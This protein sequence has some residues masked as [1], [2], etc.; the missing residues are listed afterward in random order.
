MMVDARPDYGPESTNVRMGVSISAALGHINNYMH[1]Q[2]II[3][4]TK[5]EEHFFL[6]SISA[7][8]SALQRTLICLPP[9]T[10]Q[11]MLWLTRL[12]S[13]S[14]SAYNTVNIN[15]VVHAQPSAAGSLIRLL[16]SLSN[17]DY[18]DS[19]IPRLSIELPHD[20]DDDVTSYLADHFKWPPT[21]DSDSRQFDLHKRVSAGGVSPKHSSVRF[22]ESF[23]PVNRYLDHV[24]VLSPRI[25]LSPLFYHYLKYALLE[26]KYSLEAANTASHHDSLLGIALS[27]P[28]TYLNDSAVFIPP[29]HFQI[30]ADTPGPSFLW[31]TPS[32]EAA[33]Y[34]GDKWVNILDFAS[35]SLV[36]TK[37]HLKE[38]ATTYPA[39]LEHIYTFSRTRGYS[40]LY[41]QPAG[42]AL[43]VVHNDLYIPPEE[44]TLTHSVPEMG[45]E[46]DD[47]TADPATHLS[48]K[49]DEDAPARGNLLEM[50]DEQLLTSVQ[51]LP[52]LS[53]DGRGLNVNDVRM[54][55]ETFSRFFRREVGECKTAVPA[56][57]KLIKLDTSYLFCNDGEDRFALD[58]VPKAGQGT[59]G[60]G[61]PALN[62]PAK[63]ASDLRSPKNAAIVDYMA[64]EGSG[65]GVVGPGGS[66]STEE[67]VEADD[68]ELAAQD[69]K[70]Q[71]KQPAAVVKEP[72]PGHVKE[73]ERAALANIVEH[74]IGDSSSPKIDDSTENWVDAQVKQNLA[75]NYKKYGDGA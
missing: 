14:L 32:S 29:K 26:Y 66:A 73:A 53:A 62:Q 30:R 56:D 55:A 69:Q 70:P 7:K 72:I 61:Q 9:R 75:N 64:T 49:Q 42:A 4:D 44:Y 31:H 59:P 36:S 19:S 17:A 6:D 58:T 25:E 68:S 57:K 67:S 15:I 12:D 37:E 20:I 5:H 33:L 41:P 1:P 63:P 28:H 71:S 22:L 40:M 34:F 2:A 51:L 21:S 23:W 10:D 65:G 74:H 16:Q 18:F 45:V 48:L 11:S 50:L 24:L 8:S 60:P 46:S 35:K 52:I 27:T 38:V 13:A 54:E 43:A 39:W 47:F 3:V